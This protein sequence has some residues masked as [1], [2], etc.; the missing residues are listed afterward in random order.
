ML[1][2]E[3]LKYQAEFL[4]KIH[5]ESQATAHTHSSQVPSSGQSHAFLLVRQIGRLEA[6]EADRPWHRQ[7]TF[8]TLKLPFTTCWLALNSLPL[9]VTTADTIPL[10]AWSFFTLLHFPRGQ[11][12][13]EVSARVMVIH[14]DCS[15]QASSPFGYAFLWMGSQGPDSWLSAGICMWCG[16]TWPSLRIEPLRGFSCYRQTLMSGD[17]RRFPSLQTPLHHWYIS[18]I[19]TSVYVLVYTVTALRYRFIGTT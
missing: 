17:R 8:L 14:S 11:V 4:C 6:C 19:C 10:P 18:V 9:Y 16:V 13:T 1:T 3:V 12:M 15:H 7:D 5:E 2:Q